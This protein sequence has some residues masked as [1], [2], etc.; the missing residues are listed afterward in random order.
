MRGVYDTPVCF[1]SG[2]A[3]PRC[4]GSYSSCHWGGPQRL[5]RIDISV[6]PTNVSFSSLLVCLTACLYACACLSVRP[7]VCLSVCLSASNIAEKRENGFSWDFQVRSDMEQE[8]TGTFRDRLFNSWL[9]CFTLLKLGAAEVCAL[10][11]L[12]VLHLVLWLVHI[13]LQIYG[14]R[15]TMCEVLIMC[16]PKTIITAD[17]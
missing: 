12:L 10:G 16:R 6:P 1:V 11:V 5:S 8:N 14:H 3:I 2:S 7:P 9:D 13:L 17:V 4:R 15:Q